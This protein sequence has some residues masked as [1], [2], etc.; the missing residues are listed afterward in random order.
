MKSNVSYNLLP[1]LS[2]SNIPKPLNQIISLVCWLIIP[3]SDSVPSVFHAEQ[4]Q[5]CPQWEMDG[6]V[7][8][9]SCTA[10]TCVNPQGVCWDGLALFVCSHKRTHTHTHT[11]SLSYRG[12]RNGPQCHF[13]SSPL[14]RSYSHLT[15]E[16]N[17]WVSMVL[18]IPVT[19]PQIFHCYMHLFRVISA[20]IMVDLICSTKS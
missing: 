9:V 1:T 6:E 5:C 17:D 11:H 14:E 19:R 15:H 8:V 7:C 20:L 13:H 18:S 4:L 16:G 3:F 12:I 10:E 2:S